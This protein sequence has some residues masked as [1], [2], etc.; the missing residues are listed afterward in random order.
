[1]A[2]QHFFVGGAYLGS[3]IIPTNRVIPGLEIREAHSLAL[4][5]MRCGD[6]W[7]RLIH[8]KSRLTLCWM[9]PCLSH[10]DGALS[11]LHG[12]PH[13]P[14]FDLADDWPDAAIK[15]EFLA[16][17]S[18]AERTLAERSAHQKEFA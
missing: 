15:S 17:L 6:V 14:Y 2:S 10:G 11:L 18:L 13:E 4:F 5:C 7:G 1:M 3:R 12:A 8:D 16:E 9:R